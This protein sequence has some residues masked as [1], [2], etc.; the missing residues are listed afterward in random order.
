MPECTDTDK[1][2]LSCIMPGHVCN[3]IARK[4][5]RIQVAYRLTLVEVFFT[6]IIALATV[7][8]QLNAHLEH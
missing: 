3:T 8:I 1:D 4:V 5:V 2:L 7:L 6:H